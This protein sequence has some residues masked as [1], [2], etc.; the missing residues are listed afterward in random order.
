MKDV[1]DFAVNVE[2]Q[3]FSIIFQKLFLRFDFAST[4]LVFKEVHHE[5]IFLWHVLIMQFL[6]EIIKNGNMRFSYLHAKIL[7]EFSGVLITVVDG[8]NFVEDIDFGSNDE[9]M[10]IKE[11]ARS[12]GSEHSLAF[13]EVSLGD[14]TVFLSRFGNLDGIVFQI[15]KDD[16]FSGSNGF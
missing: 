8:N 15:V 16:K 10:N 2:L 3:H 1:G 13:K 6:F 5:F 7:V 9:I 14:S 4:Q 12:I 11:E